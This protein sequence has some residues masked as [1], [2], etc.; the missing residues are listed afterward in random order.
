MAKKEQRIGFGFRSSDSEHR[1]ESKPGDFEKRVGSKFGDLEQELGYISNL[2][3]PKRKA[4]LV[5]PAWLYL[6]LLC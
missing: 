1:T 2:H 4:L 5:W 6:F 3:K